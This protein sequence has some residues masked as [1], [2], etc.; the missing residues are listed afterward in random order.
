MKKILFTLFLLLMT[1]ETFA[2][3]FVVDGIYYNKLSDGTSVETTFEGQDYDSYVNEYTGSVTI[4]EKV[5]YGGVT[6]SVTKIGYDSFSDCSGLTSLTIPNNV[7]SIG[8]YAFSDCTGLTSITI[9]NSVASIGTACFYGC[10]GLTSITIP[11]SVTSLG[12][13]PFYGAR[14]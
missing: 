2:H 13:Y 12:L 1:G 14:T 9:P 4:P 11:S 10:I 8:D 6:Y 3:D 7:D 5:T